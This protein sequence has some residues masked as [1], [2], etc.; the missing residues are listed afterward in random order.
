MSAN[1]MM[2]DGI[3]RGEVLANRG[4]VAACRFRISRGPTGLDTRSG[5]GGGEKSRC[6]RTTLR[7]GRFF[8]GIQAVLGVCIL[9]TLPVHPAAGADMARDWSDVASSYLNRYALG[10]FQPHVLAMVH[11]AQFDAVNAVIGGFTPYALSVVAPDASPEA[12]AAQAAYSVLTNVSRASLSMLNTALTESLA[13][14]PDGPAKEDGLKLG[15]AAAEAVIRLRAGDN[16]DLNVSVG[17]S[18]APGRWRPTPP[19]FISGT[20]GSYRYLTPWTLRSPSQFRPGPPPSLDSALYASDYNEVRLLGSVNSTIRTPEQTQAALRREAGEN[21]LQAVMG[22]RPLSLI[23]SARLLALHYMAWTDA[24]I[25]VFDAKYAYNYWRPVT[26]IREGHA[27]G[28]P[29]TPRDANWTPL[30]N[31]H[32][33]PEYPSQLAMITAARVGI[34]ISVLGDDIGFS[35]SSSGYSGPRTFPRL[36]AYVQDATE[37]RVAGGTHFRNSCN[38]AADA[39][40]RIAQNAIEHFLRPLPALNAGGGSEGGG[41]QLHLVT[42]RAVPYRIETSSD[43]LQWVA[44]QTNTYGTLLLTDTNAATQER[45]FYRATLLQP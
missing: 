24:V 19:N 6:Q 44:W 12:A 32:S 4:W 40:W 36:S 21:L 26:A 30:T 9:A 38:V 18:T 7:T 41:F 39:G 43:L 37:A 35:V 33:H 31:T 27:D 15:R 17:T 22:L 3:Q 29:D 11:V 13:T 45:R 28:N 20:G 16:L 34:L 23:E 42:G 8:S 10:A 2:P 14:I 25:Q 5:F 1:A